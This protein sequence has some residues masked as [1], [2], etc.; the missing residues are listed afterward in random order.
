MNFL[1]FICIVCSI[2]TTQL[3][4]ADESSAMK[5]QGLGYSKYD[6]QHLKLIH[7]SETE[8]SEGVLSEL[9]YF[10]RLEE[11]SFHKINLPESSFDH[12]KSVISLKT[13][14][15]ENVS[16]SGKNF[17]KFSNLSQIKELHLRSVNITAEVLSE[18]G[19]LKKLS[20]LEISHTFVDK[21]IIQIINQLNQLEI[22]VLKG[23]R[24]ND[25]ALLAL[26]LPNLQQLD[27]SNNAIT[28]NSFKER[29][30]FK[31]LTHLIVSFNKITDTSFGELKSLTKLKYLDISDTLISDDSIT[32]ITSLPALEHLILDNLPVTP[33]S[34]PFL[35]KLNHLTKLSLSGIKIEY[36]DLM[37]FKEQVEGVDVI[38]HYLI[39]KQF[40]EISNDTYKALAGDQK[41]KLVLKKP[42]LMGTAVPFEIIFLKE[43]Q[44]IDELYQLKHNL[45]LKAQ[46]TEF[47]VYL[48]DH[49]YLANQ[50]LEIPVNQIPIVKG[51]VKGEISFMRIITGRKMEVFLKP[52][53]SPN[54]EWLGES[55]IDL[56]YNQVAGILFSTETEK[57]IAGETF[58][59]QL[60]FF[61]YLGNPFIKELKQF[62]LLHLSSQYPLEINQKRVF[63]RYRILALNGSKPV[64]LSI[65][66][67]KAGS[68]IIH[69]ENTYYYGIKQAGNFW[70]AFTFIIEPNQL[71]KSIFKIPEKVTINQSFSIH[72]FDLDRY[73]NNVVSDQSTKMTFSDITNNNIYINS[74]ALSVNSTEIDTRS[75]LITIQKPGIYKIKLK[76][77]S[78]TNTKTIVVQ[79]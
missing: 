2:C 56:F 64:N 10:K 71:I 42:V 68:Y 61:D 77:L 50:S 59:L 53:S 29:N 17:V 69:F 5:Y 34:L 63:S 40:G 3:I 39:T 18:I 12:L 46:D 70:N 73:N 47:N 62:P 27:I 45:T 76:G 38:A 79:P 28:G 8:I 58:T 33:K 16:F 78:G 57:I 48:G 6:I 22:L 30:R 74:K 36:R 9:K 37:R 55:R 72:R 66:G 11:I 14:V 25:E 54:L 41:V 65:I 44:Q 35:S 4:Y 49:H 43:N 67:K 21:R 51:V 31:N 19:K 75:D 1:I 26:K 13:L 52:T 60:N 23:T 15:L 7:F 24:L 20:Y 32:K